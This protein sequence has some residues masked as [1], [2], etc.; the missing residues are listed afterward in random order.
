MADPVIVGRVVALWRY[1][2]KSMLGERVDRIAIDADGV[3]GDRIRA[4]FDP[5]RG[6]YASAKTIRRY[7]D[8]F[9][10][11]ATLEDDARVRIVLPDG[12]AF[13]EEA[14]SDAL[15]QLVGAPVRLA[16]W[17][18][19]HP[20]WYSFHGA[21]RRASDPDRRDATRF[22]DSSRIHLISEATLASLRADAPE[23]VRRF[24]P[25]IVVA[26]AAGGYPEEGWSGCTI[27]IGDAHIIVERPCPRCV[28][29]TLPQAGGVE[30]DPDVRR[31]L[32]DRNDDN[33]GVLCDIAAP[34]TVALG[35]DLTFA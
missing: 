8:L 21:D 13:V 9:R 28:M 1:P 6:E 3:A 11:Q 4:L 29:P 5:E 22:H 31:R 34:G 35:D 20:R 23:D 18:E 14:A 19:R 16:R 30:H 7:G 27:A 24:R 12:R 33:A 26:T 25:N 17:E 2:V 15:S 32:L 10:C